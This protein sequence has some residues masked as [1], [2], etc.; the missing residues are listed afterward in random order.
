MSSKMHVAA[1]IHDQLPK[2]VVAGITLSIKIVARQS[3]IQVE[4]K[5][6]YR[7]L[8]KSSEEEALPEM[9]TV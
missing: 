5:I 8:S 1:V 2:M 7:R 4:M 3:K 9:C 6:D